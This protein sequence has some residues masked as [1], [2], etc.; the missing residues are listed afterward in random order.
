MKWYQDIGARSIAWF[1]IGLVVACVLLAI[2]SC[3]TTKYV[4]VE[5]VRTEWRTKTDTFLLRDSVYVRD[6]VFI[7][8]IGD[9]VWYE[10]WHTKY[11]DR[12]NERIVMDS[13]IKTDSIQVPYHVERKLS[14]WEAFCIDY[15]KIMVGCTA[16][17]CLF[18]IIF[19]IYLARRKT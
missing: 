7:H 9:T 18:F 12:W 2:L 16:G 4:P 17:V 6:S 19:I 11:I 8:Q 10:R 1:I 13:F 3:T 15:G 5:T 14:R